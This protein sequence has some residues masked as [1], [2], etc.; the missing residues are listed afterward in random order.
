MTFELPELITRLGEASG[1]K[2]G[3]GDIKELTIDQAEPGAQAHYVGVS[4]EDDGACIAW[5]TVTQED[6]T[7]SGAWIGDIGKACGRNW[8]NQQEDAGETKDGKKHTPACTWLDGDHNGGKGTPDAAMKFKVHAYGDDTEDTIEN[9]HACD[10]TVWGGAK[11]P[12]A[13]MSSPIS[14]APLGF[15]RY[16]S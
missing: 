12:I 4:A 8:Y 1:A 6:E 11:G 2:I 16:A 3:P 15:E 5:I 13:G 9:D 10:A 7:A 14:L